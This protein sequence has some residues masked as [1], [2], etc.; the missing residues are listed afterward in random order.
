MFKRRWHS[1][2]TVFAVLCVVG[3]S[4]IFVAWVMAAT[5]ATLEHY[6]VTL[7][8]RTYNPSDNTTTFKYQVCTDGSQAKGLSHWDIGLCKDDVNQDKSAWHQYVDGSAQGYGIDNGTVDRTLV[9]YCEVT[10]LITD[11]SCAPDLYVPSIKFAEPRTDCLVQATE[12]LLGEDTG[13]IEYD[14]FTFKLNKNWTTQS[15]ADTDFNYK[16]A[17]CFYSGNTLVFVDG[18]NCSAGPTAVTLSSFA[19]KSSAGGLASGLWLGLA[20]LTVLIAAGSLFWAK[21]RAS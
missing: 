3:L 1:A 17:T 2:L 9:T 18:P 16:L 10:K 7:I 14:E 5:S 21:R 20:G 4:L 13:A 11:T 6:T 15:V 12:D 19:A 8:S